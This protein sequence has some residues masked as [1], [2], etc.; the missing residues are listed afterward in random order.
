[1]QLH[2][3]AMKIVLGI[4]FATFTIAVVYAVNLLPMP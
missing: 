3:S 4:Y 2:P 1:M